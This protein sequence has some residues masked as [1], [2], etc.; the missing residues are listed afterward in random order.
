LL[1]GFL[2]GFDAGPEAGELVAERL[3]EGLEPHIL[4]HGLLEAELAPGH[5]LGEAGLLLPHPL[6]QP[7]QVLDYATVTSAMAPPETAI[8]LGS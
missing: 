5:A 1:H 6:K 3:L 7:L 4:P 8:S 2:A